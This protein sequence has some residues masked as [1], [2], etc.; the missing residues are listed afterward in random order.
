MGDA[1]TLP[2]GVLK[3][4]L[5]ARGVQLP[6]REH[7]PS[8]SMNSQCIKWHFLIFYINGLV[9]RMTDPW[10]HWTPTFCDS[11]EVETGVSMKG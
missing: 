2:G 9:Q 7:K 11:M 1:G 5:A 8:R 10:L 4:I 3:R 6:K